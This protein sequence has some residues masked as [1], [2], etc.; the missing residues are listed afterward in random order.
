M[1]VHKCPELMKMSCVEN[2]LKRYK[3]NYKFH[4][5]PTISNYIYEP[6]EY[7]QVSDFQSVHRTKT[8]D[9]V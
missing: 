3:L 1:E 4:L 5:Y 9:L 2:A 6:N 7:D 8:D